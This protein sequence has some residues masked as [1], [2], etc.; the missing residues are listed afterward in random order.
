MMS[1]SEMTRR[2]QMVRNAMSTQGLDWLVC[3]MGHPFGYAKWLGDRVGLAGTLVAFPLEGDLILATHGDDVHHVPHDSLGIHHIASC[4]QPN[5]LANTHA[6]MVIE[7]IKATRPKR[8]GFLGMGYLPAVTYEN[9]LRL[10]PDVQF[11]DATDLIAPLK[12]VKSEEELVRMRA[13]AVLHDQAIEV[14]RKAVRPGITAQDVLEEVR[15]FVCKAGSRTQSLMAGSAAPGT[16]CRYAGPGDRVMQGG[17]QFAMLIE[18]SEPGGYYSEAMPTICLGEIPPALRQAHAD[19]VEIQEILVEHARPGADPM[20]LLRINDAFMA[21][22][23]YPPEGRLLGHAQG[24]DLVER[25]AASPL[26]EVLPLQ[27]NMVFS[28]HPTVHAQQAWGFP[29]NMS[30]LIGERETAR[31]LTTPN[32]IFVV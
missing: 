12:A 2:W 31:M 6:P 10:L 11:S 21:R 22:K 15:Y 13:A 29:V 27:A 1:M 24:V 4:A 5:L 16:P 26:G 20:K 3:T 32:E 7:R 8:I 14:A 28:I 18:C 19:A 25:P 30:F 17:D 23:G 9:F